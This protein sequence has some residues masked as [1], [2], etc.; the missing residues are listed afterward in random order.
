MKLITFQ[1]IEA[2][3]EFQKTG[4][5]HSMPQQHI[6]LKKYGIPYD[7]IISKMKQK[8]PRQTGEEYPVWAWAKYGGLA[9]PKKQI[10]KTGKI[11]S[12]K[13]KITFFK[14]DNQVLVSDYMAYSF[15]LNG[16]IIPHSKEEYKFFLNILNTHG[17]SLDHLKN[18][19]RQKNPENTEKIEAI[20]PKIKASWNRVFQLKSDIHQACVWCIRHNEVEKVEFCNDSK[21]LYGAVNFPRADGKRPDWKKKYLKF[22]R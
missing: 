3:N 5:L 15:I 22:I 6:D 8:I 14:P 7:F 17:I 2:F 4:I 13:V 18:F 9:A 12:P 20:F 10:N 21:F 16:Q 1:S 11:Q 19:I